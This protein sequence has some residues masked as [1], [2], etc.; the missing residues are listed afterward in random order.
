MTTPKIQ[1]EQMMEGISQYS[2]NWYRLGNH[3]LTPG[4]PGGY[5]AKKRTLAFDVYTPGGTT[6]TIDLPLN[7]QFQLKRGLEQVAKNVAAVLLVGWGFEDTAKEILNPT[8]EIYQD[9]VSSQNSFVDPGLPGRRKSLQTKD[10][11]DG[12]SFNSHQ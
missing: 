4:S 5:D 1:Y 2:K 10:V 9:T 12:C 11:Q 8:P 3:L 6:A 7:D